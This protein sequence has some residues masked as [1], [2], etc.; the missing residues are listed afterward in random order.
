MVRRGAPAIGVSAGDGVGAGCNQSVG[1]LIADL[2]YDFRLLCKVM[3]ATRPTA[4]ICLG[5]RAH[6]HSPGESQKSRPMT[7]KR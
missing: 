5:N 6:A 3:G 4:L 1:N 2:E 7:L